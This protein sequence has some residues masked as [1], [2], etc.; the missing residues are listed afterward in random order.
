MDDKVIKTTTIKK[1]DKNY[2]NYGKNIDYTMENSNNSECVN[3][4]ITKQ[5][6]DF[7]NEK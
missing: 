3:I 7:K 5:K 1:S 6:I 4:K 2:V